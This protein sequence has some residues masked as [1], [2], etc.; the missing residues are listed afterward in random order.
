MNGIHKAYRTEELTEYNIPHRLECTRDRR[1]A[2]ADTSSVSA[3]AN[4][5]YP[6]QYYHQLAERVRE[7]EK[8]VVPDRR[9]Y[10]IPSTYS[11]C[12]NVGGNVIS[13][14]PRPKTFS[15]G[16]VSPNSSVPTQRYGLSPKILARA[17]EI[18]ER[19]DEKL[20]DSL[21]H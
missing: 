2:V 17:H 6:K 11:P 13:K 1:N 10:Q 19:F 4:K 14:Y 9:L 5:F 12:S 3:N 7:L 16:L 20:M 18:P 8:E 21:M 15:M